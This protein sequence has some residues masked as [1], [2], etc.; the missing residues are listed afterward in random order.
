MAMIVCWSGGDLYKGYFDP[1]SGWVDIVSSRPAEGGE[2]FTVGEGFSL[3]VDEEGLFC[4]LGLAVTGVPTESLLTR[5]S[6][7]PV[8]FEAETEIAPSCLPKWAF[9]PAQGRLTLSFDG[10]H[11]EEWGRLGDNLL[12]LALDGEGRVGGLC[13]EGISRDPKGRAQ[14]AWLEDVGL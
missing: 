4:H 8:A 3:G 10:I 9:D 1:E 6:Q 11:P 7:V 5:P 2:A 14:A 13:F 12:W